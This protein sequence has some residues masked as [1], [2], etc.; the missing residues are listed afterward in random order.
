VAY[1]ALLSRCL[2]R[3]FCAVFISFVFGSII[4]A[5]GQVTAPEV[6]RLIQLGRAEAEKGDFAKSLGYFNRAM[7]YLKQ[8]SPRHPL[9][10]VV[11]K[12]IR[13]TKGRSLVARYQNRSGLKVFESDEPLPLSE[14]TE[15]ILVTQRFGTV[16]ARQI[17]QPKEIKEE[18]EF[19]GIGRRLTVLP[20]AGVE[21]YFGD[22]SKYSLRC[23]DA[24][25][26]AI[27]E[28]KIFDLHSGSFVISSNGNDNGATIKS[29][30]SSVKVSCES[31]FALMIGITT[32]G[33]LKIIALLG[34]CTLEQEKLSSSI[35]SPGELIF[36]LPEGFSR[37]MSVELST[38]MVT[39]KL[40]TAFDDPPVYHKKLRQQAMIQALRT[41]KR[42]K[43][44]VGD[45]K[46][47]KDFE[48]KVLNPD[49]P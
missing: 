38:L 49:Q 18:G 23:V 24:A 4:V 20:E 21:L 32:N 31:P 16:L 6:D 5:V 44:V 27:P 28:S 1:F 15:E 13:I 46:N 10:E 22:T 37:K 12:E 11:R 35:L 43:A 29:P 14:E 33:G 8:A 40:M 3:T 36:A 48:I 2:T 25:S 47:T 26:F 41:R 34:K 19:I 9:N 17:W 30:L 42:Y 7:G 39:S 45:A